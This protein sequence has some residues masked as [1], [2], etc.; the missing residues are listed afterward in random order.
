MFKT[1]SKALAI[2]ALALVFCVSADAALERT[3]RNAGVMGFAGNRS[4]EATAW[5]LPGEVASGGG[6]TSGYG[7]TPRIDDSAPTSDG[8]LQGW[9][10]R[11]TAFIV[12]DPYVPVRMVG[13]AYVVC[14]KAQ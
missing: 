10:V 14:L 7:I 12:P 6:Y 9:K 4:Y 1:N 2:G 11:F 5:C 8:E 13:A 3:V